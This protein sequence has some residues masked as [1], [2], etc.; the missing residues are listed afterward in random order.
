MGHSKELEVPGWSNRIRES[1]PTLPA[2]RGR[3]G[4]LAEAKSMS[5]YTRHHIVYDVAGGPGSIEFVGHVSPY[6]MEKVHIDWQDMP[7]FLAGLLRRFPELFDEAK[8]INANLPPRD[9]LG[10]F[11]ARKEA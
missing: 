7:R 10:R 2:V 11:R 1:C 6:S 4:S 3:T 5:E 9:E 8:A